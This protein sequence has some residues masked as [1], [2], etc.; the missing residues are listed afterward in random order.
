M[1]SGTAQQ[2]RLTRARRMGPGNSKHRVRV[3]SSD[4]SAVARLNGRFFALS[5]P[6]NVSID[7][8]NDLSYL[9]SKQHSKFPFRPRAE[10]ELQF[11]VHSIKTMASNAVFF[12]SFCFHYA[13]NKLKPIAASTATVAGLFPSFTSD[14]QLFFVSL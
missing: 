13:A 1:V 3:N 9:L 2:S 5:F 10:R 6:M 4:Q 12:F 7:F 14:L 8:S 11:R